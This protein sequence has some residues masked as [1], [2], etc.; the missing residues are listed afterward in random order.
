[1]CFSPHGKGIIEQRLTALNTPWS[2][3]LVVFDSF[4]L[5]I[6]LL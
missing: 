3:T 6:W 1:M 5:F 2:I 4:L